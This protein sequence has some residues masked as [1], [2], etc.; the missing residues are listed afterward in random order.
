MNHKV[1]IRKIEGY[2]LSSIEAAV[3]D[4]MNALPALNRAKRILIKPNLLGAFP[5]ER[6][7][8]THPVVVEAVIR[9]LRR[10]KKHIAIGDSAGGTVNSNKVYEVTGMAAVAEKYHIPLVN[11]STGGFR[12]LK[13]DGIGIKVSA[14]LWAYDAVINISKLKTHG[15]MAFTGAVK[16]LYGLIPGMI[17]TEYHKLYPQMQDFAALLVAL[18]GAVNGFITYHLMDGIIGMD[19]MGPSGGRARKFN[20]LFGSESAPALDYI[21]SRMMG[22]RIDD[23][24]YLSAVLHRDAILP[25]RIWIPY[26]FRDFRLPMVDIRAVKLQKYTMRYIPSVLQEMFGRLFYFYP[27]ISSRCVQCRLCQ[28]SCPV[29]AILDVAEEPDPPKR[30]AGDGLRVDPAICIKCMCCHELCPHTALDIHRS[31]LAKR[32]I[33]G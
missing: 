10:R 12:E 9:Y 15:L 22:F 17:K 16:N 14:T 20:V 3:A 23:V 5:P 4:Y 6:A 26:S 11:L 7:V 2:D 19:G 33:G 8:T 32:F 18:Y 28:R 31:W 24:P 21:A 25:S 30:T 29:N 13:Q 27:V 1:N